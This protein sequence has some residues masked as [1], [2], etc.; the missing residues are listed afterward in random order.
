M[1]DVLQEQCTISKIGQFQLDSVRKSEEVVVLN[2]SSNENMEDVSDWTQ[3]DRKTK[4]E[5][6]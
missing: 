2:D 5:V 4:T 1:V 6:Q 3:K